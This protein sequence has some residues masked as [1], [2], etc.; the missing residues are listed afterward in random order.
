MWGVRCEA[1]GV[2][3]EVWGVRCDVW[4]DVWRLMCDVWRAPDAYGRVEIRYMRLVFQ[5]HSVCC[6]SSFR[7]SCP[8]CSLDICDRFD[9]HCIA[10]MRVTLWPNSNGIKSNTVQAAIWFDRKSNTRHITFEKVQLIFV[11]QGVWSW[12]SCGIGKDFFHA[13]KCRLETLTCE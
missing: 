6:S 7:R 10:Q 5:A 11:L 2:R 3:C 1:W 9:V 4:C 8:T 13:L 12:C